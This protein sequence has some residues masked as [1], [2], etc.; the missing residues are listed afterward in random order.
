MKKHQNQ[1]KKINALSFFYCVGLELKDVDHTANRHLIHLSMHTV[2][3]LAI[4]LK[5]RTA[6]TFIFQVTPLNMKHGHTQNSQPYG[7]KNNIN[8]QRKTAC[9]WRHDASSYLAP[10]CV[11][12]LVTVGYRGK[13]INSLWTTARHFLIIKCLLHCFRSTCWAVQLIY[14]F[15]TAWLNWC[16]FHATG[17]TQ[18]VLIASFLKLC[19]TEHHR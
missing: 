11:S 16:K 9:N 3:Y 17:L 5:T 2:H 6:Q 4:G 1:S 18:I 14:C 10:Y 15:Q 8:P 12:F 13:M 7:F 19:L